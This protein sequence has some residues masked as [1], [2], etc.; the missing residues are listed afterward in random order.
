M[1]GM[2]GGRRGQ[3]ERRGR[4]VVHELRVPLKDLYNGITKKLAISRKKL[5]DACDGRGGAGQERV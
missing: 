4:D 1:G 2:G 3:R 5:C